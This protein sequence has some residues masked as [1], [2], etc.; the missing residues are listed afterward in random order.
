MHA[1]VFGI[2]RAGGVPLVKAADNVRFLLAA[3]E[4]RRREEFLPADGINGRPFLELHFEYE[5][6]LPGGVVGVGLRNGSEGC[7]AE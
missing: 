7:V 5:L 2:V 3:F 4:Y 6:I 1:F